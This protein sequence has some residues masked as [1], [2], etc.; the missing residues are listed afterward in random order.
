MINKIFKN[1]YFLISVRFVT[2]FAF[3][4]LIFDAIGVTTDDKSFAMILRN[5]N[6]SNLI[7][8]SYWW[9][10]IIVTAILF[11]RFWCTVCPMEPVTSFFGKIG[12][13][14][15]PNKLLRSGWVITIFYSVIL[16]IGIHTFAI[17]RI[18][19]YMAI[20]ML[21]LFGAAIVAGLIWEKRTFCTY[22]CP[23]GHLLGLYSLLSFRKLRVIDEDVCLNCKT[24][25]CISSSNHY[26]LIGRS[27]TSE[28]YPAKIKDNRA[29]ILC[30]ECHKSCTKDNIAVQKRKIAA[31]L[32]SDIKLSWA[33]ISFFL[34]VSG[35]VVYEV[36][37]EWKVTKKIILTVP[38]WVNNILN[39]SGSMR[40]T[41]KAVV[42]FFILP[43][44]FYFIPAAL[45]K[46]FAKETWKN[47]FTQ[48]V[49]AI[50]PVTASM[51]L[52]KAILKTTS[53]IPYWKFAVT[54]PEGVRS[55]GLIMKNHDLLNN[56]SLS[57]VVS[58]VVSFFA[59]ALPVLGLMLS[60]Y[61]LRKRDYTSKLSGM[62]SVLSV[63]IYSGIF[64]ATMIFWK[65][66]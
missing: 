61:V 22:V 66:L 7:V 38:D 28:L 45:K 62:I 58:P 51:H 32:F 33:E 14:K 31:D 29:C 39:V 18:P 47:S 60:F 16:I 13:K 6:L 34:V 15:K 64:I 43:G 40:G 55:A 11:G 57:S 10:F 4:L 24:K 25:D 5:T 3:A 48:L 52:L 49:I 56:G 9:P 50:L 41:V 27:C 26:K 63:L 46:I 44:L 35:F 53:R 59:L 2:F 30:G 8:W 1:K 37:S 23:V 19:R 17:H 21:V 20:Y 36:L 12:L 54:D 42:L 65:L